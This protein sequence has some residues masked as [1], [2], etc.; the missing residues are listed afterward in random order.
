MS[1][2]KRPELLCSPQSPIVNEYPGVK[3]LGREADQSPPLRPRYKIGGVTPPPYI[4]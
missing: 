2:T 1:S 3:W 4:S